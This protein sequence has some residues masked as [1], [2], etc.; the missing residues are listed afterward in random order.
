VILEF[1]KP[2]KELEARIAEL[3]RL[4]GSNEELQDEIWRLEEAL[5]AAK[6]RIYSPTNG[7]RSPATPTAPTSVPTVTP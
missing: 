6:V 3:H 1:E 4:A 5:D 7:Y 2:V